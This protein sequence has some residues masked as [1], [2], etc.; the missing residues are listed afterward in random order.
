MRIKKL[1]KDAI[2]PKY[3]TPGSVAFDVSAYREHIIYPY[4][5]TGKIYNVPTGLAFEIPEGCEIN[6]RARSGLSLKYPNYIV[7]T[8]GGTIDSD[9]RG[10]INIFI[11][12]NTNKYWKIEKGNR[13]AQCILHKVEQCTFEVVDELSDTER[14]SGGFGSTGI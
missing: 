4:K 13:I 10:P 8:G 14:G 1:H 3:M 11:V 7:M 6:I 12:N 5:S 2:I 9:Y